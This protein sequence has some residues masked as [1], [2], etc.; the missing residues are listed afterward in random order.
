[1]SKKIPFYKQLD[2][3]DCGPTCLRMIASYY[4]KKLSREYL[5]EKAGI[6]KIGVT[7]GGIADAAEN[8]E[9]RTL[10]LRVSI[11]RLMN[12]VPLPCIVPWEQNH[13]IVVYKTTKNKIFVADPAKKLLSYR[14]E[15]FLEKWTSLTDNTGYVLA[16]EPNANF[17]NLDVD[18][19][20]NNRGLRFLLPYLKPYKKAISQLFIGL[21]LGTIIQFILPFLIQSTIDFGVENQDI[22]FIYIILLA[23]LFLFASQTLIQIFR[24][25][26]LLHITSRLN[27]K[28]VSDFLHKILNLPVSYFETRNTGEHLQRITDHRRIQ[29]FISTSSFN[30]VYSFILFTTFNIVLAFYSLKVFFI[31]IIGA[32]LYMIWVLFFLKQR[33]ELDF[34]RFDETSQSQTALVEIIDGVH[35]IKINNSQRKNRWKW[36]QIQIKLFKTSISSLSLNHYQTIGSGFINEL[37]N[38]IITFLSATLV[39]NG[40]ITLGIMLSIQYIVGQLNVPL[41]DFIGF[42][43]AWQDAKLSIERLQQVHDKK[44]EDDKKDNKLKEMPNKKDIKLSDVSFRYGGETTPYVLK[45]INCTFE[46]GKVTAIVGASGSGKTT[47]LK[48]LLKFCTPTKGNISIG[49]TD[50]LNLN[51]NFW[52]EN[53]GAVLQDT[54]I[55]NDTIL[56]NIIESEQDNEVNIQKLKSATDIANINEFVNKLPNKLNTSIGSSGLQ[57]S[58]GQIQRIVIGRAVYKNP[59]FVFFDEATSALDANNEKLIMKKLDDFMKKRTAIVIAHRLS[60]VKNADKIIVLEDGEIVEE[61]N[62]EALTKKKGKYY[63]LVKNQLELGS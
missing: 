23:Q 31:F 28:M 29:T 19:K 26:L 27:I 20:K 62:H 41:N 63:E 2:Y 45:N 37:K 40:E 30:M 11:D 22:N 53:C 7:L 52:R 16:I 25:W 8:I 14:K 55:F 56:G 42:I 18:A 33:A 13:F 58:G 12:E 39:V 50:L 47:L 36:E 21:L 9:M 38:I 3:R 15:E 24:E 48:L 59:D 43:Q 6:T 17:Y 46:E 49:E 1:M 34:K 10:G 32:A 35:E 51:N 4:G 61:G 60:T 54:F 57:L 5:R 44:E